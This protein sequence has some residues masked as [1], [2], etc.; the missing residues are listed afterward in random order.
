MQVNAAECKH[1][2]PTLAQ[3]CAEVSRGTEADNQRT[4][5]LQALAEFGD[6]LDTFPMFPSDG[7]AQSAAASMA[8]VL[9]H[10]HW[11]N[12][13]SLENGSGLW[14]VVFQH[15]L[16]EHMAESVKYLSPKFGWTFKMEDYV[17]KIAVLDHS[18]C[19]GVRSTDLSGNIMARWRTMFDF[20]MSR[21]VVD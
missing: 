20:R 18:V 13:K 16:G 7:Q 17:G 12:S 3:I 9:S 21:H 19:F 8:Q 15:H 2:L 5:L 11:L 1:L 10:A 14:H 4:G 6:M